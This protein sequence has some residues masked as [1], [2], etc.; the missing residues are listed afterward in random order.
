M[1]SDTLSLH[2]GKYEAQRKKRN[3]SEQRIEISGS[4]VRNSSSAT[5]SFSL[6]AKFGNLKSEGNCVVFAYF[7]VFL[8]SF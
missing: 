8:L 4:K 2:N 6:F 5:R 3:S 7:L 1:T